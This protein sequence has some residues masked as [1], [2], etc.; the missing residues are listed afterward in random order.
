MSVSEET[1][2]LAMKVGEHE[3][4]LNEHENKLSTLQGCHER[5]TSLEAEVA[6]L[7]ESLA[8]T[9]DFLAEEEA[10]EPEPGEEVKPE[11]Q[12]K[13]ADEMTEI[14]GARELVE[15]SPKKPKKSAWD[16]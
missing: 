11:T 12:E 9:L 15:E 14:E 7:K 2:P 13:Q 6:G 4:K 5:I 3:A 10:E 1:L 16:I 8:K